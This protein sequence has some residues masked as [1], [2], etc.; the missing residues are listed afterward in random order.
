MRPSAQRLPEFPL[1]KARLCRTNCVR[2]C[3]D[4]RVTAYVAADFHLGARVETSD[5]KHVGSLHR[6]VVDR[7][8]WDLKDIVVKETERFSGHVLSPG[9]GL[10]VDDVT[11]PLTAVASIGH[12]TVR[13]AASAADV[14]RMPPYL[15]Y[16]YAAAQ[17][18]DTLRVVA[19]QAGFGGYWPYSE[20]ARKS[21]DE[22]EINRDE[23]VMLGHTGKRLGRVR[24]VLYDG[25]ELVGVVIHPEGWWQHNVVLQVRFLERSDDLALF[26]R[27]AEQDIEQLQPFLPSE[28]KE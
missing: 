25:R 11:V 21:D 14:R 24:D 1:I 12:D 26:A 28:T 6:L 13:L 17:P 27:L 19:A 4:L 9:S 16:G 22:L 5:G 8:S 7:D 10:L 18:G 3:H 2:V 23:N 20:T 15:V